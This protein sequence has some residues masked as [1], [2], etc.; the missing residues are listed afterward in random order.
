MIWITYFFMYIF[1]ASSPPPKCKWSH[2]ITEFLLWKILNFFIIVMMKNPSWVIIK[3]WPLLYCKVLNETIFLFILAEF[4]HS[5]FIKYFKRSIPKNCFPTILTYTNSI[6]YE[7][8]RFN[9]ASQGPCNNP[10]PEPNRLNSSY[11]HLFF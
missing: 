1:R 7:T 6:T 10:Y 9:S 11:W 5:F 2:I 3:I 4:F 8:R